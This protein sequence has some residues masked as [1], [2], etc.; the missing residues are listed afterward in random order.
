MNKQDNLSDWEFPDL[1]E[2]AR[3]FY[4]GTTMPA[5]SRTALLNMVVSE[6]MRRV[7]DEQAFSY[8]PCQ[9]QYPK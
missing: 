2:K 9:C 3:E 1:C 4:L 5:W 6:M 8:N 7:Y